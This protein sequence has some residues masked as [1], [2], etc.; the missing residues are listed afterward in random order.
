M[1]VLAPA[2]GK[3]AAPPTARPWEAIRLTLL[4]SL[5]QASA[6]GGMTQAQCTAAWTAAAAELATVVHE[7][8]R[9]AIE[10]AALHSRY[11][12]RQLAPLLPDAEQHDILLQRLLAAAIPL[13]RL[14]T[15]P[16]TIA[17]QRARGAA[18]ETAWEAAVGI[19]HQETFR[20]RGIAARVAAWHRPWR[21]V[22][23]ASGVVIALTMLVAAWF[24]GQIDAPDWFT[25]IAVWF[26]GLPWL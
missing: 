9:R 26:W 25:P 10:V 1:S 7:D 6:G 14:A 17:T 23:V 4:D 19:A 18:L 8:A 20:W 3:L 5:V 21:P 12:T 24:G 2:L 13:E 22:L 16:D 15:A 11:P